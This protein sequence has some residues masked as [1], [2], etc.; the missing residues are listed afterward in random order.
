MNAINDLNRMVRS[1]EQEVTTKI[2]ELKVKTMQM[3]NSLK[4]RYTEDGC[5][6]IELDFK[7]RALII[8]SHR[9][10]MVGSLRNTL[11]KRV[12]MAKNERINEIF[13]EIEE[14]LRKEVLSP[15]LVNQCVNKIDN[16]EKIYVFCDKEDVKSCLEYC[17]DKC[18]KTRTDMEGDG[19]SEFGEYSIVIRSIP[20][21]ALG[22]VIFISSD[23]KS[24]CDNSFRTRLEIFKERYINN[25]NL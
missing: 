23:G 20:T 19:P 24:I 25:M 13:A 2:K 10:K 1:I 3:Y 18:L 15:L 4:E 6:E 7:K 14:R 8:A 16:L 9:A 11:K 21:D 12:L 5:K 22:G 17:D